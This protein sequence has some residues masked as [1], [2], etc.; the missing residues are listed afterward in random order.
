MEPL[1]AATSAA[2]SEADSITRFIHDFLGDDVTYTI[3]EHELLEV[4]EDLELVL[5]E[6]HDL[7]HLLQLKQQQRGSGS[8]FED[9]LQG[10]DS[11]VRSSLTSVLWSSVDVCTQI[12][13]VLRQ[14]HMGE[15]VIDGS[16]GKRGL[17]VRVRE[18]KEGLTHTRRTVEVAFGAL[19][20]VCVQTSNMVPSST[21]LT[22]TLGNP[23]HACWKKPSTA[24]RPSH[25]HIRNFTPRL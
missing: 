23:H 11:A 25:Q 21:R 13:T 15:L 17:P 22:H 4:V 7:G 12:R 24:G 20:D 18:L 14:S 6:L 10:S 9:V 5:V 8:G 19:D 16:G 2:L 3:T 1:T